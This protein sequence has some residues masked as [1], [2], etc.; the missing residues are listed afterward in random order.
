MAETTINVSHRSK[1]QFNAYRHFS[2][3][4]EDDVLQSMLNVLPNADEIAEGC[5]NPTCSS[6]PSTDVPMDKAGGIIQW[7]STS[8]HGNGLST[9]ISAW[10]C[11]STCLAAVEDEV[12]IYT[13][14]HP[15]LV[16]VGGCQ[17]PRSKL[18]SGTHYTVDEVVKQ[19]TLDVPG[20][21]DGEGVGGEY[22]YTGEPVYIQNRGRWIE[23][24]VVDDIVHEDATTTLILGSD[25][26]VERECHPGESG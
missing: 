12:D 7:F 24:A 15:D 6:A 25:V 1:E 17:M 16:I 10:F 4:N 18:A 20:A 9:A 22:D 26:G 11:S 8:R 14:D 19:V 21:F 5:T 13:P 23:S 3:G 2:H